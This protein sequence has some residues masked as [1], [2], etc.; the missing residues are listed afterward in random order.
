MVAYNFQS[1]FAPLVE[2]GAKTQTIRAVGNRR[3]AV[4]G[5]TLQLYTGMR[6]KS[7]RLLLRAPCLSVQKIEITL[8]GAVYLDGDWLH[9][10]HRY[11]L[12]VA[13]GFKNEDEFYEFFLKKAA[14]EGVL[15]KWQFPYTA[16]APHGDRFKQLS[17]IGGAIDG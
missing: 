4:A 16:T 6:T 2:S 13:D 12:A 8:G 11:P 10:C 5:N 1:Q 15:I 3:H 14:F 17:L 9:P 7:C